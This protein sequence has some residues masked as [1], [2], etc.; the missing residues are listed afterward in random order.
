MEAVFIF[1]TQVYQILEMGFPL[2]EHSFQF[3]S[4][5]YIKVFFP[6]TFHFYKDRRNGK[7]TSLVLS[8]G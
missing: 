4:I 2:D 8:G 7:N 1:K 3:F 5:S 6:T